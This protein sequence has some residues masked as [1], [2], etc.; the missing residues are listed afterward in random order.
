[1]VGLGYI[2]QPTQES[3]ILEILEKAR[4]EPVDGMLFL[5]LD[6]PITQYHARIWS[7]QKKGHNIVPVDIP[8]KNWKA[9]RLI[10][11]PVQITLFN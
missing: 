2:E 6:R 9:Y 1:M 3:R 10:K 4:G 11:E 8:G 7:L 5:R